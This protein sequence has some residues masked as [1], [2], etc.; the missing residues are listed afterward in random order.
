MSSERNVMLIEKWNYMRHSSGNYGTNAIAIKVGALTL[1]FSYDTV[2]AF[3]VEGG[4]IVASQNIW[5]TTTGKHLNV[6]EPDKGK[7]LEYSEFTSKLA[8]LL[9]ELGLEI[10]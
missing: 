2:V 8:N 6:I 4:L 3:K 1:W 7:R 10:A 9:N 5:G